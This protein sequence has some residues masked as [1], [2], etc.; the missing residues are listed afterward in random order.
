[1]AGGRPIGKALTQVGDRLLT[2]HEGDGGELV[3]PLV[4]DLDGLLGLGLVGRGGAL[5]VGVGQQGL[6]VLWHERVH[7]VPEVLTVR[8]PSLWQLAGEVLHELGVRLHVRPEG[9]HRELV[10]VGHVH[11][12][13]LVQRQQLFFVGEDLLE[14]VLVP[15]YDGGDERWGPTSCTQVADRVIGFPGST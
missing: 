2:G 6:G 8:D 12:V 11:A 5:L 15:T 4:G 9:G 1:M 3:V 7:H 13:H 14:K 10:I